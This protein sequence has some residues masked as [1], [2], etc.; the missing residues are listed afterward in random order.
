VDVAS[1]EQIKEQVLRELKWDTRVDETEIGVAVT[2]GVVTLL[3]TTDSYVKKIAAQEAAHRVA[4]VLDV[5]NDIKVRVPGSLAR[6]D[7]DLAQAVRHALA[8]DVLVPDERIRSTVADG[9]VT[10]EGSVA[11]LREREDAERAVAH[12]AGVR[13]MI[14]KIVVA[15]PKVDAGQVRTL[16]EEALARRAR[17][18]AERMRVEVENGVV[19][20]SGTVDSWSEKQAI[21]AVLSHTPGVRSVNDSLDIDPYARV[22]PR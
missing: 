7:P 6:S 3:G 8:W 9:W 18:E 11:L 15:G 20:V 13:G 14:N 19:T 12:L 1:N 2:H 10:L 5:A 16:I 4:G 17:R 22:D 21:L